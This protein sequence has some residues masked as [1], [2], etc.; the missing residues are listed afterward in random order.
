[1]EDNTTTWTID[2]NRIAVNG[3]LDGCGADGLAKTMSMDTIYFL[4]FSGV[5]DVNFAALRSLLRCRKSGRRFS[6]INAESKVAEK[7]EDTG[8]SAFINICRKPKPLDLS[9]Y[10]EFGASFLSK[11]FNSQDGDSMIKVY[12][13]N[14]PK[15]I[16][17]QEKVTA[18]AVMQ[19]GI[20]TPLVGTVYEEGARTAL[21]FERIEGKKSFSRII[22]EEPE[23]MEEITVR[24]AKMCKHLH[25]T[26][27]DT[28]IFSDRTH[29]YRNAIKNCADFTDEEKAKALAFL[30]SIPSETTCLHGDMQ[31][32][33]VITNGTDDLWIDLSDFGYGNHM[34]DMG[35]W[36][37]QCFLT[38]DEQTENLYH[39]NKQQMA[40]VWNIFIEEYFGADT[41]EKKAEVSKAI[42][43]YAA[44]H[45]L[46]LGATYGFFPFMLVYI[47]ENLMK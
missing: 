11:A 26:E 6:V 22:S 20:P 14:V 34:L 13:A 47:R 9:K 2:G 40:Q 37:F 27:C 17:A 21:D 4:D 43:P 15:W 25:S 18:R 44:L 28:T 33:N 7:F 3:F 16:V 31:F 32:S 29:F 24:F 45:M 5:C 10:E 12:G 36:F 46:Y 19:F 35:M 39:L 38:T 23:R 30:N 8:V 41:D 1:M 42:Q